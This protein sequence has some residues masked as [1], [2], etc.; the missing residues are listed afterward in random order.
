MSERKGKL[1]GVLTSAERDQHCT[2]Y[3]VLRWYSEKFHASR[4]HF[5]HKN[6]KV[7]SCS[8]WQADVSYAKPSG[9]AKPLLLLKKNVLTYA[10]ANG[11]II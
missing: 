9:E 6:M 10:T 8:N 11:I 2:T 4:M 5:T 7:E 3:H 1:V